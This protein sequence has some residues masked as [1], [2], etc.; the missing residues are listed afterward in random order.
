MKVNK[1]VAALALASVGVSVQA[2][3]IV[4]TDAYVWRGD[5]IIQGE[6]VAHAPSSTEIVS[7]YYAQPHYFMPVEHVWKLK[8]DISMYPRLTTS[9]TLHAAVFNMGLD[10]MVNAV[11][12]DTTL[13]TGKEWAGVWTRDV[14][15]SIIL[16]M[17]YMQPEAS[18]IS[19][20]KKVNANGRIIQ[21]TGSGGA[22]PVSSDRM[23]WA[24]AA[25]EVYK[26]TGDKEWLKFIYPVI[27][28]SFED[29]F[30]VVYNAESGLVRGETSFI[31]WREQSY[32]KWMQTAD[33]YNSEAMNTS[34]VHAEGL[35]ILSKI[36]DE[37]GKKKEAKRY[38][39]AAKSLT[40]AINRVFWMDDKGYY[41]M[42]TYG[43][44]N[45]ILNPRA[46]TLGESLAILFNVAS[47]ERAKIISQSNPTTPYGVAIFYP[48]I[49]DMPSYHNNALWPFV[50]SYWTLACAKAGN[51]QATLQGFGSVF[52]PAALFATNK[53]NFNLDNGDI[54]TELNS[55]NMLWS[56]SGNI[57]LT[58][59]ILFGI[60]YEDNGLSFSPFVPKV[61]A[62]NRTLS[63]FTYRD[64]KLNITVK[65][66][67]QHIKSF[68]LN[69]K[70]C[71]PFIPADIKGVNEIV[72]EMDC[73]EIPAQVV[74]NQPNLKAPLTPIAWIEDGRLCW[75]PIEYIGHYEVILNGKRVAKTRQTSYALTEQG[76]WQVIGVS[77]AGVESFASEPRSNADR[78]VVEMPDEKTSMKSA[79]ISYQPLTPIAGYNGNGFV[80]TD[81]STAA[82]SVTIDVP[83]DGEYAFSLRY[84]N[85][86]GPVNTENKC[87]IRTLTVDGNKI[88]TVVMPHRGVA[89]WDDWGMTN[90][91]KT[92]LKAGKHTL[93][94]EYRPEN[95]NMNLSTNHA[96]IDC[97][98]L[99][100]V[101]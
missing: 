96:I 63:N 27:R 53:E 78:F 11:E 2:Q 68:M 38:A 71:K 62:D 80:E 88:G 91:V 37:L 26:V 48:Q 72:I 46:E 7:S 42:Y 75:N 31:D 70:E 6:Y 97:V 74:N 45:M 17:A 35:R 18:K 21:D 95:E 82:I 13:R 25:Y 85:G 92:E 36:A 86:N 33:I 8:N 79:E 64:A 94:I 28:D 99:V 30:K 81:H 57:A 40:D 4:K 55:S 60:N 93:C 22:W 101:K 69:G 76:E 32:P 65:G 58:C 23:I 49:S 50:A 73:E 61:M 77:E 12:P 29:D 3:E 87:A 20:M 66:H 98:K 41:A 47:P 56:L 43:R 89:N 10:E 19:L 16:S 34:V 100:R 83:A 59:R 14:S 24:V 39:E 5:S 84:A 90:E 51:E 44:E 1:L 9:N 54:A 67:G 52:R 15:Y